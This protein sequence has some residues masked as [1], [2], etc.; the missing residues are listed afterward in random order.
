[1]KDLIDVEAERM[2]LGAMAT[3]SARCT[4]LLG[5]LTVE[6]FGAPQSRAAYR[7]I[8]WLH[9]NGQHI[10]P[11]RI[12]E[13]SVELGD[14]LTFEQAEAY[15]R[16]PDGTGPQANRLIDL[17]ER[18]QVIANIAELAG[19][20]RDIERDPFD[21][22]DEMIDRGQRRR[23]QMA[24]TDLG[25][26]EAEAF[27]SDEVI[28]V[29]WVIP[30]L[31][32]R[33]ARA[34]FVGPSGFG[35]TYLLRQIAM[36]VSQGMHPFTEERITPRRVLMVEFENGRTTV[37]L[38]LQEIRQAIV[39]KLDA[40]QIPVDRSRFRSVP[41]QRNVNLLAKGDVRRLHGEVARFRP[42]L[43]VIGPIYRMYSSDGRPDMG[44]ERSATEVQG[45]LDDIVSRFNLSLL[46]EAHTPKSDVT[47]VRGSSAWVNWPD[48][49]LA[50]DPKDE[51]GH[52]WLLPLRGDRGDGRWPKAI[53]RGVPG[54][55]PWSASERREA[56][57]RQLRS[58]R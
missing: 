5:L 7:A 45:V 10:T 14:G 16:H 56:D 54:R 11:R 29:E 57:D 12:S 6:E 15:Q 25:A 55:L 30:G 17:S 43:L 23:D 42:D 31:L 8:E 39:A 3:D 21:L 22:W 46:L 41:A 1:M 37:E 4:H 53:T 40:R 13:V 19:A 36:C 26:D 9:R 50:M 51:G 47:T 38:R 27:W 48:Y 52:A 33:H 35:K 34:V 18:R 49:G 44:G 28:P 58:V 2:V 20:A 24:G 32:E